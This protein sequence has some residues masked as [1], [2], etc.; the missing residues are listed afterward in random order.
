MVTNNTLSDSLKTSKSL[1]QFLEEIQ[2]INRND[3]VLGQWID[4]KLEINQANLVE[5]SK[6]ILS[7]SLSSVAV[8]VP[9]DPCP[10]LA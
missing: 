8:N 4:R 7:T 3:R 2:K 1:R 5:V 10:P 6:N 9:F